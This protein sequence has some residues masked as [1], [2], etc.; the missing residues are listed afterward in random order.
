MEMQTEK[1][2]EELL[3]Q[4]RQL[5]LEDEMGLLEDLM[6]DLRRRIERQQKPDTEKDAE[7]LYDV[8]D[9]MGI[10]HGTWRAIGGVDEFIKQERA[11]WD[12]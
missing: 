5:S 2:R 7:P 8:M 12:G 11:S 3:S 6:A 10:G 1:T 4:A 9:F